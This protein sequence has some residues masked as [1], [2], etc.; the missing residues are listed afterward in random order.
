[1][2]ENY[3]MRHKAWQEG[4]VFS[5]DDGLHAFYSEEQIN[6]TPNEEDLECALSMLKNGAVKFANLTPALRKAV[7]AYQQRLQQDNF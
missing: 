7:T 6:G 2:Q 3:L 1:M 4:A 5:T